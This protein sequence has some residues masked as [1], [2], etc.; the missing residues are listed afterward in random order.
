ME[1]NYF[2]KHK[3]QDLKVTRSVSSLTLVKVFYCQL[4]NANYSVEN[5]ILDS[6]KKKQC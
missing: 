4:R 3:V 2:D 5:I 1:T 6:V